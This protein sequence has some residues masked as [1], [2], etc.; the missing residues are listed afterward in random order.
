V[1]ITASLVKELRETTGAGMMD[2]K[3]ALTATDGDMQKAIDWLREKGIAKAAKK[4]GRIAAE[5]LTRV[6]ADGNKAV[7][8]EVNTETDFVA[9]NETF[10]ALL[11]KT[12]ETLLAS[13]AKNVEEA[14][15]LLVDGITLAD[16]FTNATATIGEKISLRR[17][18][19]VEKA[20]TDAFGL[21]MHN[22]GKISALVVLEGTNDET[23]A[24][25]FAMQLSAMKPQ[26]IN[27]DEMPTELVEHERQIIIK[28]MENDASL[29]G[30][31]EKVINGIVSGRLSKV[32]QDY[33]LDD[34]VF[35]IDGKV[36]CKEILKQH[37]AK[38][39]KMI[40]YEAGEGIEKKVE[41]FADEVAK[42]VA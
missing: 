37:N 36:K 7:I 39:V 3:K 15:K 18:E 19:L 23:L 9:I 20:S 16:A 21:Y 5:G 33:C 11:D 38:C 10:L 8:V 30:K 41:D 12:A 17:F 24:K 2:C 35:I 34:Q 29:A 32:L 14:S 6:L 1:K 42:I 4:A 40:R 28:N 31:P 25:Q 27:K 26:F 22:K 13:N